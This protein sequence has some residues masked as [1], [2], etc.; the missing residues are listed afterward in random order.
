M[1]QENVELMESV[2]AACSSNDYR[3]FVAVSHPE[4]EFQSLIAEAEGRIFK[5]HDGVREWFETVIGPLDLKPGL[6]EVNSFGD[7]GITCLRNTGTVAGVEVVQTMW[8]AWRLRDGLLIW[9]QTF[10]TRAD[11]F[12]AVGLSE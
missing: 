5:G 9:W 10:R 1:S 7:R 2:V 8:M 6:G 11:A 4:V 12:E 3:A